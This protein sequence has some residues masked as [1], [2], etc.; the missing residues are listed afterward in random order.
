M[1][2]LVKCR[3]RKCRKLLSEIRD[4]GTVGHRGYHNIK[5][6]AIAKLHLV[7]WSWLLQSHNQLPLIVR[8]EVTSIMQNL[9]LA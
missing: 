2:I 1:G 8:S 6:D 7:R 4:V 5:K 3:W 9:I